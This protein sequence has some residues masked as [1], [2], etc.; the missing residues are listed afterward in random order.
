MVLTLL[1]DRKNPAM[2]DVDHHCVVNP[3]DGRLGGYR[4]EPLH[5]CPH[6]LLSGLVASD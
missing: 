1:I 3:T 5:G 6:E 2:L 4:R